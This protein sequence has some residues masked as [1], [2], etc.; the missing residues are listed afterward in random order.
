LGAERRQFGRRRQRVVPQQPGGFLEVRPGGELGD[1]K[2]GDNQLAALA[3][4]EAQTGRRRD[5]AFEA[6]LHH[7]SNVA[8]ASSLCQC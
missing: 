4:D 8:A 6:A 5:D 2:S 3:V 7:V 1:G